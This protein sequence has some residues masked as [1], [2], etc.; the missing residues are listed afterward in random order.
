[1]SLQPLLFPVF[2][3]ERLSWFGEWLDG[4]EG[5]PG[6]GTLV[7]AITFAVVGA[8]AVIIYLKREPL[9]PVRAWAMAHP[10]S[11][12][13]MAIPPVAFV[14]LCLTKYLTF[15]SAT[16]TTIGVLVALAN[17]NRTHDKEE[18]RFERQG[19][20]A[21]AALAL[22]LSTLCDYVRQAADK[23]RNLH[24]AQPVKAKVLFKDVQFPAVPYTAVAT[25]KEMISSTKHEHI[26]ERCSLILVHLQ[27]VKA[28]LQ[29]LQDSDL[30]IKGSDVE[31]KLLR[32]SILYAIVVSLFDYAR[33]SE[34]EIKEVD[35]PSVGRAATI[36][37]ADQRI[38][39]AKYFS[40]TKATFDDPLNVY[41][42]W[43][44]PPEKGPT[45]HP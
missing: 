17:N 13:L 32:L 2:V 10:V 25:F 30:I 40:N 27:L 3:W 41:A 33:K 35:W 31:S 38:D 29:N 37:G 39:F 22:E 45:V 18:K 4:T 11:V 15:A 12:A 28:N 1:M 5:H 19:K 34:S 42:F 21:R 43:K 24:V 16:A 14:L 7:G 44:A 6:H 8:L 9:R 26:A 20:A 36:I 23:L